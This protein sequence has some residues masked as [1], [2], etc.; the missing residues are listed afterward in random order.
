[1]K[2]KEFDDQFGI[3]NEVDDT[4]SVDMLLVYADIRGWDK[5]KPIGWSDAADFAYWYAQQVVEKMFID[6][7]LNDGD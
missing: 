7:V 5:N 6:R 4:D 2:T 1:M 3:I